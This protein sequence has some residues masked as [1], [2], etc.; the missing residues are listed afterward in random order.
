MQ[1]TAEIAERI[2]TISVSSTL[3]VSA[4]ADR[5]RREGVDVV[6]FGA[7]EPD[8]PTPDNIKQAAIEAIHSN[9]TKYTNAGGTPELREAIVARHRLDFGTNYSAPECI[10][11]VG[12]KHAIFN[13]IQA[14]ID[15]G[16]EVIIPVPYWVTYKDVVNYAGGVCVFVDTDE[17]TGFEVKAEMIDGHITPRTK[18]VIINSPGNPSGAVLSKEEFRR[19]FDLTSRRG[20]FLL[21]DECYCQFLYEDQPFS[22]AAAPGA[23]ETVVVAGSLSKTYSMT[24]WRIGFALAPA[25]IIGAIMKLQSHS[26]SNPTSIA[27]KAAIEAMRGPQDSVPLMLAEYRC[28]RDFVIARLREIPGVSIVT[29]KGAFYAYP[30]VSVAFGGGRVKNSMEFSTELLAKAHVA[31]VPGEAFGT[32]EHV[33]ISYATSLAELERGLDRLHKFI[34]GLRG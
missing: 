24:G 1:A 3:K 14:L 8:F 33:R 7:G 10:V 11:T 28:R 34:D 27:Q 18:L 23:K 12:G 31:V 13:L 30:N 26:T 25:P 21:T 2:S 16:D 20:I 15:P 9:F 4:D 5:L 29:P 22:I 6:D 32:H 19:I 17:T